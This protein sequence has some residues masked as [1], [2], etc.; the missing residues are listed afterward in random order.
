MRRSVVIILAWLFSSFGILPF[1]YSLPWPPTIS[2]YSIGFNYESGYSND[3]LTI[4]KGRGSTMPTPEWLT[5]SR[6]E[7]FAYIKSQSS[8]K[9]R[10]QFYI[11]PSGY[12]N[13]N[14]SVYAEVSGEGIGYININ[15]VYFQGSQYST[16]K[17][18][19]C[20]GS[21]AGSVDIRSFSWS[22]YAAAVNGNPLEDPLVIGTTGD[23]T[24]YVLLAAPQSPLSEPWTDVLDYSCNWA[25]GQSSSSGAMTKVVQNIYS[26]LDL[27]YDTYDGSPRYTTN[28][29]SGV[30]HLN[31]FL[32]EVPGSYMVNCYD[33]GKA[34]KVFANAIGC[35]ADYQYTSP[36]GYLNCIKPIG[37][38]WTNNPFYDSQSYPYNQPIV[39]EDDPYRTR[40]G[41]HA[42]G[43]LS[44]NIY[45][46]CL[47]VDTDS[48]PDYGPP[49]SESWATGWSWNMYK[50]MVIDDNPPSSPGT[51]VTYSFNID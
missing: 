3:A 7:R 30:F 19:T 28:G 25:G 31:Q 45:D 47:K 49:F 20:Q 22:W 34:S 12:S 24:Y 16:P 2:V 42:F 9:V 43:A 18:M 11:E 39:G 50:T 8:R 46:A 32:N 51:P 14:I 17:V 15:T 38:G 5:G 27:Y 1:A 48:N 6:N 36:F 23:H 26:N 29:T 40:F 33:C 37:C 13:S 41:N 4:K 10:V 21:V 35:G 44:G